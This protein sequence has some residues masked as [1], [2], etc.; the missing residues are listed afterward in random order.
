MDYYKIYDQQYKA[1]WEQK[2]VKA[3]SILKQ[4]LTN[5][6]NFQTTFNSINTDLNEEQQAIVAEITSQD[7]QSCFQL[8]KN[9]HSLCHSKLTKEEVIASILEKRIKEEFYSLD[10]KGYENFV[11]QIAKQQAIDLI[12]NHFSNHTE[13]YELIYNQNRFDLFHTKA[14]GNNNY[15]DSPEYLEM[16]KVEYKRENVESNDILKTVVEKKENDKKI[17]EMFMDR[18]EIISKAFDTR[19]RAILIHLLHDV[20]KIGQL[21]KTVMIKLILIIGSTNRFEIFESAASKSYLYTLTNK[22]YSVFKKSEIERKI[23]ILETK[24][25]NYGLKAIAEELGYD[26]GKFRKQS[27]KLL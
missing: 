11:N 22:K 25:E 1:T 4:A 26:F 23:T 13:Y 17:D 6:E 3:M 16:A 21:D 24:L 15:R 14:F 5:G 27:N 9:R 20:L 8:F 2:R 10:N 19:E 7:L 18:K 12:G